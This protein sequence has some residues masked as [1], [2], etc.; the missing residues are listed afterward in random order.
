MANLSYLM[1]AFED[2]R[3]Y[4]KWVHREA[5]L[6]KL[7]AAERAMRKKYQKSCQEMYEKYGP[8]WDRCFRDSARG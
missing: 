2:A 5:P 3:K 4:E 7:N 1:Q 6:S 8:I